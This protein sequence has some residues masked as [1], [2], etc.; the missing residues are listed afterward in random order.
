MTVRVRM[1]GLAAAT[2]L[3]LSAA[4]DA[5]GGLRCSHRL[6]TQGDPVARLLSLCGDPVQVD[7]ATVVR[8]VP[9]F[10]RPGARTVHP[11][12]IEYREIVVQRWV[13]NFGPRRFMREVR[14][15]DGKVESIERLGRGYTE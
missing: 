11:G 12:A 13:Y 4:A 3:L 1:T 6:I 9:V 15:E 2:A 7:H 8:R 10:H 14:I 5:K